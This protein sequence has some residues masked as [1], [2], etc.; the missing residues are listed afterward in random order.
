MEEIAEDLLIL[1]HPERMKGIRP[2]GLLVGGVLG[3]ED[4]GRLG[5]RA[6]DVMEDAGA[7]QLRRDL[8]S[9]QDVVGAGK[10]LRDSSAEGWLE[11]GGGG[12]HA[13]HFGGDG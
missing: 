2:S 11:G 5:C 4:F 13:A 12:R 3:G 6:V 9:P 8:S 1:S 10:F 7:P